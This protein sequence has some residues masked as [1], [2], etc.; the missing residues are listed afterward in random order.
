MRDLARLAI[1]PRPE[2]VLAAMRLVGDHDDVAAIGQHRIVGLAALRREFL[3]GRE[4]HAAGGA[5]QRLLQVLTAVGLPRGLPE[6]VVAHGES[7]E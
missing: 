5:G 2:A 4:H 1:H 7:A 3:D 6:Q